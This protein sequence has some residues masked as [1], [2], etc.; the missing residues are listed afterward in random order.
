MKTTGSALTPLCL[1]L[2]LG[3]P[4]I[5]LS[6]ELTLTVL[7]TNDTY[8][9]LLTYP[10]KDLSM[11]GVLRRA[12]LIQQI[13]KENQNTIVLDAGDAIGP[14]PL[15]AFDSGETV[16]RMMNMMGYTA[17]T[18][19]NHEFS[20]GLDVLRER[21]A[22]AQF[23]MLSA[24][25]YAR[26]TS[27]LLTQAYVIREIAGVKVGIVG[28]TTPTTKYRASP[29]L[30]KSL[31]FDDP[32]ASAKSAVRELKADGCDLIIAL[33]HLGYQGDMELIAQVKE[34]N[35]V[36][37]SEVELPTEKTISVMSP[38][39]TTAGTTMVY[40]PWFGGYLGRVDI[41]LEKSPEGFVVKNVEARHYRLDGRTYPDEV[42]LPAIA[43]LKAELDNHVKG[44]QD[45]NAGI[46]GQVAEGE[47][48]S[49]LDFAPLVIR[50]RTKAEI[51]L[52]NRGSIRPETLRGDI[53][54]IQITE[55]IRYSN[56]IVVLELSGAQLKDA[57][58]H[59][60]KQ[61]SESRKLILL[62]LDAAGE[63]INSRAI[64]PGEYYSVAVN[65][66]LAS[67][68]DGYE[69]LAA[70]RR[71]KRTGL[72]L[73]QAVDDYIVEMKA[74]DKLLSL[75]PL[76]AS[77]PRLLVKSKVDTDLTLKG[78]TISDSA[79]SY[80][81]IKLLQSKN[82]GDFF[83]WSVQTEL[84]TLMAMSGY[85]LDLGFVSKYGRLQHP[86]LP[87]I[88][89]DDN[90]KASAVFRYIFEKR[91]LHPIA[92]LE[93][94]NIEF[95]PSEERHT[96]TQFSVGVERKLPYGF[97]L[98]GGMLYRRHRPEESTENQVN[99][100]LRAQYK[101]TAKGFQIQSEL[102]FF[103]IIHTTASE[104]NVFRDYIGALTFT[105]RFPVRKYLYLSS[106]IIAY[107][108][109]RTGP[110]AHNAEIAAQLHHAWGK[111]P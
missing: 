33:S 2:I 62:G 82:M 98:S 17:M 45:S 96:I 110:W 109:T 23:P 85:N 94:E 70:A 63:K 107:R 88:E 95:T 106:S 79:E 51:V 71:K 100:D 44:Y 11:G 20:Y 37:G 83:H 14:Y 38:I 74:S 81:Q 4:L 60:N 31:R 8:G 78:I 90:T 9:R 101:A 97:T 25:T 53:R 59:S 72:F 89:L 42:T 57:L 10:G 18:L 67:G 7:H 87:S 24:N 36:V 19:G 104:S 111:K 6:E 52:L 66:F 1:M 26:D 15:A 41:R 12:Y 27:K 29:E 93:V 76:R 28:L 91:K 75:A 54:R 46:L 65:D 84:S 50:K 56:Q 39:D 80:P 105:A 92:R 49:V 55:S 3:T 16:I 58:T 32:I 22:Q 35:L 86:R 61:V 40:C 68:G 108:E 69:M 30:Q 47:E 21:T 77:V 103:P 73:R 43:D 5:C 102:K 13:R 48:I 99:M 64:N 34:I